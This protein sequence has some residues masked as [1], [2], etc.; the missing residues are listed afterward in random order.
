MR[1]FNVLLMAGSSPAMTMV[2]VS[3]P[4]PP[5]FRMKLFDEDPVRIRERPRRGWDRQKPATAAC[6]P[7]RLPGIHWQTR[8]ARLRGE[9]SV[10]FADKILEM[11][12]LRQ[13][14]RPAR[15]LGILL[16]RHRRKSCNEHDFHFRVEL[17]SSFRELDAIHFRHHDIREQKRNWLFPSSPRALPRHCHRKRR[18]SLRAQAPSRETGA[19]S[20]HLLQAKL[21]AFSLLASNRLKKPSRDGVRAIH[22]AAA[23]LTDQLYRILG[24]IRGSSLF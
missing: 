16:Q 22:R 5:F 2:G 19:W 9:H 7:N 4:Q 1:V 11:D 12:W 23:T 14:P 17:R 15:R 20:R 18:H 10:H 6:D 13:N 21:F 24:Q 3:A 8:K